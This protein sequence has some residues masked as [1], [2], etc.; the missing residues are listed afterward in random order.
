[1]ID[2]THIEKL[3]MLITDIHDKDVFIAIAKGTIDDEILVAIG[4]SN[5]K[6]TRQVMSFL[7]TDNSIGDMIDGIDDLRKDMLTE[8]DEKNKASKQPTV[9]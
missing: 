3:S 6:E 8:I 2:N 7:L 4:D 5:N 1:M 9:A